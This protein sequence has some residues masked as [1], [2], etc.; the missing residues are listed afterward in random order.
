[1]QYHATGN[2]RAAVKG[3]PGTMVI[4]R[5]VKSAITALNRTFRWPLAA[6]WARTMALGIKQP[7]FIGAYPD[8]ATASQNAPKSRPNS[9]DDDEVAPL[10]VATMSRT[11]VWDYP[12]LLWLERLLQPGHNVL[13][14]G[15]HLGT[16]YV[17]WRDRIEL[18]EV[19]WNIYDV[20]ATVRAARRAQAAG[21]VPYQINFFD[22]PASTPPCDLL[23]ASGLLQYIDIPLPELLARLPQLPRHLVLNKVAT[24][25]GPDVVTLEL[26]GRGR[27]PYQ[28]RNRA[29]FERSI[30]E[31]GY[32]MCDSW[33][34]PSL[35]RRIPTH[36]WIEPST[37]VGYVFE[38][39][40]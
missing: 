9:Y 17:A 38:R 5:H 27:V 6:A 13:D 24:T 10:N 16:K 26:I 29:E 23:L 30:V 33:T 2:I 4:K 7:P 3:Y 1:M 22:D 35:S 8:Y 39:T 21:S 34:I 28:M 36:P 32:R 12:M 15:G 20:P 14:A 19:N 37:S 11:E 18:G 40:A 31:M 25:R